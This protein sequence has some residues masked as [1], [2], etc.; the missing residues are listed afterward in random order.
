[1]FALFLFAVFRAPFSYHLA[2]LF[3]LRFTTVFFCK[4]TGLS[5]RFLLGLGESTHLPGMTG[6]WVV[7]V[8]A[9]RV[10]RGVTPSRHLWPEFL[11]ERGHSVRRRTEKPFI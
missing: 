6:S 2:W 9:A 3:L 8:P 5:G 4:G 7:G 11:G 10:S 1:M